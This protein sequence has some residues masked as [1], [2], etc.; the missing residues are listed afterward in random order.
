MEDFAFDVELPDWRG[1][2]LY[3]IVHV[4][5]LEKVWGHGERP[6]RRLI[7]GPEVANRFDFDEELL[8]E[9]SWEPGEASGIDE[10]EAI[11]DDDL[12]LLVSI[13]RTQ[14]RFL[15]KWKGYDT[16]T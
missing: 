7:A 12:P 3:P 11:L 5:R 9:D 4:S 15:V 2:E 13:N 16:P 8:P 1:Y 14:Q 10:V 6:T